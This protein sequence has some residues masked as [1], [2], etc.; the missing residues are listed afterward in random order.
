MKRKHWILIAAAIVAASAGGAAWRIARLPAA[1]AVATPARGPAVEAIYATG[2][3]EPVV[4]VKVGPTIEGRIE[5]V[6]CAEGERVAAGDVLIRLEDRAARARVAELEAILRFRQQ[7]VDRY[8][9]LLKDNVA[10]RQSYERARSELDQA[11]AALEVARQE[12]ADSVIRSPIDGVVLREEAEVGEV[13]NKGEPLCW[14]GDDRRLRITAE[15]DEEDVPRVAVGQPALI[16]ADAYPETVFEGRVSEITPQGDPIAKSYRAR[17]ALPADTPLLV[18]MTVEVNV[19]VRR[20][21]AAILVPAAALRDGAVWLV[22]AGL[23]RRRPVVTGV[24][25]DERVEIRDGLSDGETVIL[26]P[27]AGLGDGD[28]VR[29]TRR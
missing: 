18:G 16:K 7:E 20:E 11:A 5:A 22:E 2:S 1:V 29:I 28:P 27:P 8:R 24:V 17:I 10:S 4:W 23:A 9:T 26:D 21:A 25:G 3:V 6:P 19:V 13:V 12:L 14:I 15:V